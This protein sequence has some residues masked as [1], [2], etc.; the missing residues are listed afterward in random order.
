MAAAKVFP[1][2]YWAILKV[3]DTVYVFFA[4]LSVLIIYMKKILDSAWLVESSAID[5]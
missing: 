5:R 4:A 3:I 2:Y 1:T